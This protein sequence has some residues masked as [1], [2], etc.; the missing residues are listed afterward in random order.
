MKSTVSIFNQK[1]IL[2]WAGFS[3]LE[4]LQHY[5]SVISLE[6]EDVLFEEGERGDKFYILLSGHLEAQA[7]KRGGEVT[8]IEP[9]RAIGETAL[10]TGRAYSATV[11]AL[12]PSKLLSIGRKTFHQLIKT[13]PE[14]KSYFNE[15]IT[16]RIH[17]NYLA[18]SLRNL[19]G[20]MDDKVIDFIQEHVTWSYLN[21]GDALFEEGAIGTDLAIVVTGRLEVI[22]NEDTQKQVVAEIHHGEMVGEMALLT[23]FRRSATVRAIRQTTIVRLA[24]HDFEELIKDYPDILMNIT[25]TIIHR[26]QISAKGRKHENLRSLNFTLIFLDNL[27]LGF[28]DDLAEQ[29]GTYGSVGVYDA[30][31]FNTHY[32]QSGAA[33][34]ELDSYVSLLLNRWLT[35]LEVHHNYLFMVADTTWTS[36]TQRC[37]QNADRILLVAD[38]TQS[39]QLREIEAQLETHFPQIRRDI[40]LKHPAATKQ[41]SGTQHWLAARHVEKHH[42]IRQGDT[43]HFARVARHITGNAFG[44]ALSGGGATGIAHIGVLQVLQECGIPIDAIGGTSIGGLIGSGVAIG[45]TVANMTLMAHEMSNKRKIFDLTLPFVSLIQSRKISKFLESIVGDVQIEDLWIPFYCVATNLTQATTVPIT[46]GSLRHALRTSMSLPGILPPIKIAGELF[47]DGAIMNNYPVDVMHHWM[48]GGQVIGVMVSP[49][50]KQKEHIADLS[51]TLSGWRILFNRLNPFAKRLEVPALVDTLARSL[52][53]NSQYHFQT[54][55]HLADLS[56]VLND[57]YYRFYELDKVDEIIELGY[58]S[59]RTEIESWWAEYQESR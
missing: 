42:H 20:T 27:D 37:L 31:R 47:V 17:E 51:P 25:R 36:W 18:A 29:V 32:G 49:M 7:D 55:A 41:P 9:G 53:V 45:E 19:F 56:I 5:L 44:L 39:P 33:Q 24:R 26:Q 3:A 13:H 46:A 23:D 34:M 14:I 2:E 22:I 50:T 57:N 59:V 21:P 8:Q 6:A 28:V 1:E 16:P 38:S 10:L 43:S 15:I 12:E 54:V 40:I 4:S 11:T 48:E 35:E 58:T 30:E 52:Q